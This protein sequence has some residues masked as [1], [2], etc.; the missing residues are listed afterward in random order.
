[1]SLPSVYDVCP[2]V[3]GYYDRIKMISAIFYLFPSMVSLSI[4][5]TCFILL[6]WGSG[7]SVPIVLWSWQRKRENPNVAKKLIIVAR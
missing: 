3:V 7:A 5:L 6:F 4:G 1:M 2:R